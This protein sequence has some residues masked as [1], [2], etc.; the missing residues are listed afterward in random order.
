V[1]VE[2]RGRGV[3]ALAAL[4][5]CAAL[6]AVLCAPPVAPARSALTAEMPSATG[7]GARAA[8]DRPTVLFI[9]AHPDDE[10]MFGL[11]RF[12][13][14]GWRVSIA[15]VTNGE[16]G[17]VVQAIEQG[18]DP[19][20]DEDILIEKRPGCA[21]W[22]T[23]PPRGPRL[24]RIT[25]P[26][27]LARE[28]RA[29]FLAGQTRN[30]VAT[31]YFLSGLRR[32]DFEDSWDDGVTRWDRSLLIAR[33]TEVVRRVCPD[34][35]VT[36]NPGETWAHPQHVG[37][38]RIVQALYDAG[39]FDTP[40]RERPLLYGIREHGWYEESLVPQTGDVTF[41]RTARSAVLGHTYAQEWTAATSRYL[42]QSSHPLWFAARVGAGILPGYGAVDRIRRLDA[43]AQRPGLEALFRQYPPDRA[44]L[45][46]LPPVPCLV[47]LSGE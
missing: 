20:V 29:E 19:A 24:R 23:H 7:A 11:G 12:R 40:G 33:L 32:C 34:V 36:L 13:E 43:G 28:R 1:T 31:V 15:L 2:G 17:Q 42:S 6:F 4:I 47:D 27:A 5:V 21:T 10:T 25:T 44:A 14:R 35:V 45:W 26:A 16:N 8:A 41:D 30:R 46:R 39:G 18:Y 9:T 37:L 38:G 22:L 3:S